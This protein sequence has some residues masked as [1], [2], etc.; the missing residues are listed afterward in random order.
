M[1]SSESSIWVVPAFVAL[2]LPG[3]VEMG[4]DGLMVPWEQHGW[5][6]VWALPPAVFSLCSSAEISFNT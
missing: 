4:L 6:I 1:P 3:F 2:H 5:G